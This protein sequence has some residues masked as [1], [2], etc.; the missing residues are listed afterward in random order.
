MCT[1]PFV[2]LAPGSTRTQQMLPVRGQ[3]PLGASQQPELVHPRPD[4][5]LYACR[6]IL[7]TARRASQRTDDD[8]IWRMVNEAHTPRCAQGR[9][10]LPR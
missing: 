10:W 8:S 2:Q 9:R 3:R 7:L 4:T 1:R 6:P 5:S